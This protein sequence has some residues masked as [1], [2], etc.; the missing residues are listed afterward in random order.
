MFHD[1]AIITAVFQNYIILEDFFK[2]L[3]NQSDQNFTVFITDVSDQKQN[4]RVPQLLKT[5]I[6][7]SN[8]LGYA[9]SIN[10]GLKKAIKQGFNRF[11]IVNSDIVFD[12]DF[13]KSVKRALNEKTGSI[14]GGKIF[15]APRYEFHKD[16]YQKKDLGRVIWYAGG[17]VDWNNV[18]TPHRGIDQVDRGQFNQVE[19]T[20]F[21]NGCLMCFD[22]SV[23]GEIGFWDESYFLFF[24][25][26]DYCERAKRKGIKLIYDPRI[27]IWHKN[28]QSTGG[29]G[30]GIHK[31]YQ[32]KNQL[33]FGLKYAPLKSKL[34]LLKNYLLRS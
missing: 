30:S 21:V 4:I 25:D 2:S 16:R 9:H 6:A 20:Q 19:E 17:S 26:S 31:K 3:N 28:S 5:N 33:I 34:H 15:Y 14:V 29:A 8:N 1:L 18:L 12:R 32:R 7:Y 10:R 23:I 22:K 11:C 27:V 13:V 24:E